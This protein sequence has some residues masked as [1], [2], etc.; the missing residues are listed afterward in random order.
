MPQSPPEHS[1]APLG[2]RHQ[3]KEKAGYKN[4]YKT[5]QWE[6]LR[7]ATFRRDLW[8]C[9][10]EHCRRNYGHRPSFLHC[11]HIVPH[12]GNWERFIDRDNL[13]TLCQTCH[14]SLKQAQEKRH[15]Y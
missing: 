6:N 9:Q 12:R 3:P 7:I 10:M 2:N 5:K 13:Q 11:D 15:A 14:N 1:Y 4:W 8:T